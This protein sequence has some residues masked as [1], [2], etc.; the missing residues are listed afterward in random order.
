[1]A[2][3][4]AR[5]WTCAVIDDEGTKANELV[6]STGFAQKE[7][8]HQHDG[9]QL[10]SITKHRHKASLRE[11]PTPPP[12]TPPRGCRHC[13]S[14]EESTVVRSG[15]YFHVPTCRRRRLPVCT[16]TSI[17]GTWRPRRTTDPSRTGCET[18]TTSVLKPYDTRLMI[19][20]RKYVTERHTIAIRRR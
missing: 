1:V 16:S 2:R 14:I 8:D 17:T 6:V 5:G 4:V 11:R 9:P 12:S 20:V 18:D 13:C 10:N 3:F 15:I 7:N 19:V